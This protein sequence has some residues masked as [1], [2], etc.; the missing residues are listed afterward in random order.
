[1]LLLHLTI[2]LEGQ[3]SLRRRNYDKVSLHTRRLRKKAT[4]VEAGVEGLE[5]EAG[6]GTGRQTISLGSCSFVS[7][8]AC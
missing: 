1:M 8:L 4:A 5:E 2:S 6:G 7:V 3:S